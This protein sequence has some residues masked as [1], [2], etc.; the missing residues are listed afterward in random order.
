MSLPR[1]IFLKGIGVTL[2]LPLLDAMVPAATALAQTA[3]S[4]IR[5][6]G[7]IYLPHG[8]IMDDWTPA[9]AGADFEFKRIMK[10]LEPFRSD[11]VVV[12][13]MDGA[14][15]GGQGGHATGPASYLNDVS[16]RQTEGN[17]I[18]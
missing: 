8:F 1:R 12:S 11:M 2:A 4:P 16:P 18:R 7:F 5:R 14:P 13:G 9:T 10:P 3:A 17:D 6:A 15:N